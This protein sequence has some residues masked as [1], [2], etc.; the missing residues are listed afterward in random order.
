MIRYRLSS[1]VPLHTQRIRFGNWTLLLL[2]SLTIG[3]WSFPSCL[4]A[5][6][7]P[8]PRQR[9]SFNSDWL[10]TKGD[11]PGSM[12]NLDYQTL[13]PWLITTGSELSTNPPS[14]RPDGNPGSDVPYTQASFDDSQW[15]KL[16]LPHDWGIEG[17][18]KQEYP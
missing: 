5:A 14:Q 11:P 13:K 10:F 3:V 2:W 7:V 9:L 12:V 8:S 17:P 4:A 18:F 6:E 16:N 15:R 1:L